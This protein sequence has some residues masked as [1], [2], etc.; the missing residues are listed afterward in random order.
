MLTLPP[1][2]API[3]SAIAARF[4]VSVVGDGPVTLVL[5]NGL[6]TQQAT[7]RHVVRAL[8]GEA[9]IIR[10]DYQGTP[11]TDVAS[12]RFDAYHTLHGHA[13]DLVALLG[14]LDV[15]D[16]VFVG[17]SV[18]AMLGVLAAAA[19]PERIG[20]LVL[21]AGSPRYVNAEGYVG[22]FTREAVDGVLAAAEDD[23]EAWVAGFAPAV[24]G[25]EGTAEG[26][27]EFA[28][29]LRQMRPDIAL[30][31]LRAIFLSDVRHL[32][33]ATRQPAHVLQPRDDMAVPEVVGRYLA[34][35]L[36]QATL[37]TLR[38]PGHLPHLTAP[39]V[40]IPEIRRALAL[41]VGAIAH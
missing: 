26:I 2:A 6:G 20:R 21:L 39:E 23:F 7:W 11:V 12:Y 38:A 5:G 10:F 17:H 35:H 1:V 3:P 14:A 41:H 33:G 30:Q 22:G 13:D 34:A 18:S 29:Y 19:V 40:V 15:R 8:Q 4:N 16:T 25:A 32:L 27:E 37:T 31:T 28:A 36:P 9:R 24:L